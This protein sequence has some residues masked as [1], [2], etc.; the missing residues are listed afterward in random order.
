MGCVVFHGLFQP[1]AEAMIAVQ[2]TQTIGDPGFGFGT[3]GQ[4][5]D[6]GCGQGVGGIIEAAQAS[7]CQRRLGGGQ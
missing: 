2:V 3:V 6:F 7:Q 1:L 4:G 5:H